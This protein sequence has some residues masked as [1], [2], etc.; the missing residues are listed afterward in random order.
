MVPG[1][2]QVGGP[3]LLILLVINLLLFGARRFS[4]MAG[5]LGRLV[6]GTQ[7]T[8]EDVS[9][10]SSPRRSTRPATPSRI[11]SPR[12]LPA[13]NGMSAARLSAPLPTPARCHL[14]CAL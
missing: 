6:K 14:Q 7:H 8:V 9:P 13:Q 1:V 11:S 12:W 4:S 3:E 10:S 2:P 5:E